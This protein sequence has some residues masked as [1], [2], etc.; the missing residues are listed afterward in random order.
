MP[1]KKRVKK[2]AAPKQASD[3]DASDE[4]VADR[5]DWAK[6][7]NKYREGELKIGDNISV[8]A[9]DMIVRTC[10]SSRSIRCARTHL[11]HTRASAHTI[12]SRTLIMFN[13]LRARAGEDSAVQRRQWR[14]Y[15]D[16]H[17]QIARGFGKIPRFAA[18]EAVGAHK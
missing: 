7:A 14:G 18:F 15:Y 13:M 16:A 6:L 4:D 8:D 11:R 9:Q 5:E 3:D 2:D 1:P 17:D 10:R 12:D